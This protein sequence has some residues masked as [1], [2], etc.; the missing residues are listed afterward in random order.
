MC[1]IDLPSVLFTLRFLCK[2]VIQKGTI[3]VR[4]DITTTSDCQPMQYARRAHIGHVRID[5]CDMRAAG[6]QWHNAATCAGVSAR[7][8]PYGVD[9][10]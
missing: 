10:P 5:M 6:S 2:Y 9:L 1:T 3:Q 8:E 4:F 7:L